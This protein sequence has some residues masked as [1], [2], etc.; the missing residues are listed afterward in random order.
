M[1]FQLIVHTTL[2]RV[3]SKV[4]DVSAE[5]MQKLRDGLKDFLAAGQLDYLDVDTDEGWV[6]V[7]AKSLHYIEMEE[8]FEEDLV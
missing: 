3:Y 4:E 5:E 6:I 7:P 1:K 2:D 8:I